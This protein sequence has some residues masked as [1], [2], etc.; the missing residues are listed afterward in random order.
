M[1]LQ[2][3]IDT[4]VH[5]QNGGA[6]ECKIAQSWE[7]CLNPLW[8]WEIIDYRKKPKPKLRPWKPEEVPFPCAIRRKD[9]QITKWALLTGVHK[10][11]VSFENNDDIKYQDLLEH[12]EQH[13]GKP[14]GVEE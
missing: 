9:W 1:T 2:E 10:D 6:V 7:D 12:Y 3:Q 11:I 8:N 4:M 14:C 13:D 5:F